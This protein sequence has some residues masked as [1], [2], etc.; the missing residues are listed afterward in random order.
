MQ[1]YALP[2]VVLAWIL[3]LITSVII[4]L[5]LYVRRTRLQRWLSDDYF[6]MLAWVRLQQRSWTFPRLTKR[7]FVRSLAPSSSR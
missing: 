7:S 4:A 1:S 3:L 6:M 5:R 2:T